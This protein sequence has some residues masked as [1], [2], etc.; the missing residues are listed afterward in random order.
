LKNL[1]NKDKGGNNRTKRAIS[2]VI[3]AVVM[4]TVTITGCSGKE[5]PSITLVQNDWTSQ[6]ICTEIMNQII[7]EQLGYATETVLLTP[8]HAWPTME[9]GDVDLSSEI[10][11]PSRQSEIQ[12]YLDRGTL[13]LGKENYSGGCA[14]I[15]PRFVVYGDPARGIEPMAPDL[16]SILDLKDEE[17]G[18]KGYWK[19]FENPENPGLGELVG[20]SP[21]WAGDIKDRSLIMGYDLPLWR[22]NQTEALM[23]ARM[24]SADKEGDPLLM[25]IWYP[26]WIFAAVDLIELTF[27]NPFDAAAFDKEKVKPV[28]SGYENDYMTIP[29]VVRA[30]L[31]KDAPDVYRLV[32]SFSIGTDINNLMLRVD[33]DGEDVSLVAADW[34]SKNQDKIDQW[35]GK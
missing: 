26:H 13:E 8:S 24:I 28:K 19:L 35:L 33:V 25:Y 21:G 6:V 14:W 10:W 31:K 9:K 4:A 29:T 20:G 7:T 22:S 12:P 11:L 1:E 30:G 2:I 34:I 16:K 27:P 5:K 18:G 32:K 17:E 3:M 15:I 23:C